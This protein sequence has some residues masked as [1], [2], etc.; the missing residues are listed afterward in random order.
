M[1]TRL[2]LLL[3]TF[4]LACVKAGITVVEHDPQ[5]EEVEYPK[6]FSSLATLKEFVEIVNKHDMNVSVIV[7]FGENYNN[8]NLK[9][10]VAMTLTFPVNSETLTKTELKKEEFDKIAK[11]AN[12]EKIT[13]ASSQSTK[14]EMSVMTNNKRGVPINR[15]Y[16]IFTGI[17]NGKTGFVFDEE[18]FAAQYTFITHGSD[19]KNQTT[20]VLYGDIDVE[21]VHKSAN[22]KDDELNMIKKAV[23][24]GY[25][26][27]EDDV[28]PKYIVTLVSNLLPNHK[29]DVA[30]NAKE[31]SYIDSNNWAHVK[32]L[33]EDF[34]VYSI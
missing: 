15:A 18:D 12:A 34:L 14:N 21:V 1:T 17:K 2:S 13:I 5:I 31:E 29:W 16:K 20:R 19:G 6:N 8:G 3:F 9:E 10:V 27:N 32:I 22:L 4:F 24:D 30:V 7:S 33:S 26:T 28:I 23:I 25:F 11:I